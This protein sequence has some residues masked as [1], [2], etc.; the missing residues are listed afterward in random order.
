M[1]SPTQKGERELRTVLTTCGYCQGFG[2]LYGGPP[3]DPDP[4]D[5][6]TCPDCRGYGEVEVDTVVVTEMEIMEAAY[7][8]TTQPLDEPNRHVDASQKEEHDAEFG[9]PWH[10]E[11]WGDGSKPLYVNIVSDSHAV[12]I[13]ADL[14]RDVANWIVSMANAAISPTEAEEPKAEGEM[15]ERLVNLV[16]A[17]RSG[18][19]NELFEALE[20]AEFLL[21]TPKESGE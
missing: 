18:E 8:P 1:T 19:G 13:A 6:G 7:D 21:L 12:V 3:T 2:R 17:I 4:S 9:L 10:V 16:D 20:R 15:R 11:P 14:E 5:Y